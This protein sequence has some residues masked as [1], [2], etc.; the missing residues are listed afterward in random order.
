MKFASFFVLEPYL[1]DFGPDPGVDGKSGQ[2]RPPI[3]DLG[4]NARHHAEYP[5]AAV[6]GRATRRRRVI[7][8][9]G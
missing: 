5:A 6:N 9:A 3:G 1:V 7:P 2:G 4:R 8:T